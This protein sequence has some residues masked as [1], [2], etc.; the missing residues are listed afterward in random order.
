V[1]YIVTVLWWPVQW[2]FVAFLVN[3]K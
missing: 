3:P 1:I 2:T